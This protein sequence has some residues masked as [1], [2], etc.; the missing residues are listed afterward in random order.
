M[1]DGSKRFFVF[2]NPNFDPVGQAR[3][4]RDEADVHAQAINK[5]V[6]TSLI[7]ITGQDPALKFFVAGQTIQCVSVDEQDN[8]KGRDVNPQDLKIID[9]MIDKL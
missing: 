5:N 4:Y 9:R 1:A 3:T 8:V 6:D 2:Y 7:D